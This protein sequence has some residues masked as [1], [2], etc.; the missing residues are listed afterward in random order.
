MSSR[1]SAAAIGDW[2][3]KGG[4][5]LKERKRSKERQAGVRAGGYIRRIRSRDC[6]LYYEDSHKYVIRMNKKA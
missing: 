1:L 6:A 3:T 4:R 5:R 2:S